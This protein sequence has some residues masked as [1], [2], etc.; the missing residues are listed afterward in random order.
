MSASWRR[1]W[2]RRRAEGEQRL[3][4]R[5]VQRRLVRRHEQRAGRVGQQES[6]QGDAARIDRPRAAQRL[7]QLCQGGPGHLDG[8][9]V[10]RD[11]RREPAGPGR[12]DLEPIQPSGQAAA[13]AFLDVPPHAAHDGR[14]AA[15]ARAPARQRGCIPADSGNGHEMIVLRSP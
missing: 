15:Q 6:R 13:P 1:S 12:F 3:A 5:L 8:P 7:S 9:S 10:D 4:R 2:R 11:G 14:S